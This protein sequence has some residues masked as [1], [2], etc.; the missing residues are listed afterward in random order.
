MLGRVLGKIEQTYIQPRKIVKHNFTLCVG[1]SVPELPLIIAVLL[2][3][4]G[5]GF[6]LS[7]GPYLFPGSYCS[8]AC[9]GL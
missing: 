9:R 4:R 3:R 6:I 8:W 7:M 1:S 5:G 2:V